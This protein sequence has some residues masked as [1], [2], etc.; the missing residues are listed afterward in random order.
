MRYKCI[1]SFLIDICDGDGFYTGKQ[2]WINEGTVWEIGKDAV[3]LTGAELHLERIYKSK[4]S[5]SHEW[6]EIPKSDLDK[7]FKELPVT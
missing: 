5:K 7:Y 6:I 2:R 1:D 3:N 4:K